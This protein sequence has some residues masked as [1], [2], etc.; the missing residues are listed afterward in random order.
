MSAQP[1]LAEFTALPPRTQLALRASPETAAML[2]TALDLEL[3]P[4]IGSV[5]SGG[6]VFAICIGPDEFYIVALEGAAATRNL[7]AAA[8]SASCSLVDIS[9]RDLAFEIRGAGAAALL[10][11]GCP[12][13]LQSMSDRSAARTVFD[14]VQIVL[15]KWSPIRFHMHVWRSFAPH[16]Q[17]IVGL[18]QQ[19]I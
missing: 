6:E 4:R 15:I 18:T 11:A 19:G 2:F 14:G 7:A 10:N 17:A 9:A 13:D 5:S 3:P 8:Q 16:V 1:A 12:A